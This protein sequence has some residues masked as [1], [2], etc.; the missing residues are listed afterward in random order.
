MNITTEKRFKTMAIVRD[1]HRET[2]GMLV[3][4]SDGRFPFRIY[5]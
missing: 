5:Q 4:Y 3:L 1:A 2:G